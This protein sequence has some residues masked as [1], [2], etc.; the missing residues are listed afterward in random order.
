MK[1]IFTFIILM[2]IA[3]PVKANISDYIDN[4][5]ESE[6]YKTF[7]NVVKGSASISD[8]E[9]QLLIDREISLELG[10]DFIYTDLEYCINTALG[11]DFYIKIERENKN[12]AYWL[13]KN[14]QFSLLPDIFYNFDIK[15]LGGQYLVGGIVATTTHEVPIQSMLMAEW[16][17]INQ[18]KYFFQLAM[19]RNALKSQRANLEYSREETILKTVIAYYNTLQKKM[20][21]EVQKVNLFDRLEQLNYT[22]GRFDA[23][24]GTLLDV[25]RAEAELASARQEYTQ[26]L[27]SLRLNQA[28]LANVIGIDVF[29]SVYPFEITV[30]KRNLINKSYS[31]E[32]L[33]QQA[34]VSREDIRAK[35]AEINVYR[36]KR[37][38]NYT[39]I[40]PEITVGYQNG[41]VGTKRAGLSN[42]NS[43]TL[44]VRAHLGNN[45]LM[46]TITQ[47]KSDSAAVKVKKLEL[48][49]LERQIKENIINAYYDS[50]TALKKIE[51]AIQETEAADVSLDLSLENMKAGEATFI[52]VIS[53]QNL[54]IQAKINLITNM[55]EYNK[56]QTQLL[57]ET[58][59]ISPENVLKDYKRKFY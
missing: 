7:S 31:M 15:N 52:D 9:K 32:E 27:N 37:S 26:T 6:T 50:E 20:E 22:K 44:D 24:L 40:I 58:G 56:A 46:G 16:S 39:D 14:A 29:S 34:L 54:K 11:E 10:T 13:N 30:D 35:K 18:G 43:L 4:Y 47:I 3:I 33:F 38:M 2:Y 45:L 53:A 8:I 57:F 42:N 19:T 36:A 17:T 5:M 21:I 25:K 1:I 23:G 49:K 51:A 28:I 55:I 41:L 12:V 48:E 59:L